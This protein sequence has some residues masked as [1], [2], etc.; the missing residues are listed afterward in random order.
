MLFSLAKSLSENPSSWKFRSEA[1]VIYKMADG[2]VIFGF[3]WGSSWA[4]RAE[5]DVTELPYKSAPQF[6]YKGGGT[7]GKH[8]S[9]GDCHVAVGLCLEQEFWRRPRAAMP[10][11]TTSM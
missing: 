2:A 10:G 5:I 4:F 9:F 7:W 3:W 1:L 8:T 11:C 6:I